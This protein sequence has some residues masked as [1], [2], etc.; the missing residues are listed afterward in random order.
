MKPR[1]EVPETPD[2][3]TI[4]CF[5]RRQAAFDFSWHFH[6]EYELTLITNGTGTRYAGT[7]VQPYQPGDLVLLGPDLPHTFASDPGPDRTAEAVVAQFREDFLG[8][9]FLALPQFRSI[10][11]LL[12]SASR[13]VLFSPAPP[14]VQDVLVELPTL[15]SP[16]AQ[17]IRLLEALHLLSSAGQRQA[18]SGPGYTA[19][20]DTALRSRID[21]ICGHLRQAHTREIGLT[22]VAEL[23]HMSPTSFS[24]FFR[25]AMGLTLTEYLGQL[26]VDTACQLLITTELPVTEVSLRSGY[27]NLSNFNRRFRELKG[28]TPRDYRNAHRAVKG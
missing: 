15:D 22:E 7:S 16:A 3:T 1:Q 20:P 5:I 27:A 26:R 21:K 6:H 28:M 8:P 19:A 13:G 18:I 2:G 17:T 14:R 23:V 11:A 12:A 4:K 25:R 9:G 24:R 10:A